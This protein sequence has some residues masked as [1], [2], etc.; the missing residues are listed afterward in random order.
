[1]VLAH[2][3]R[4]LPKRFL[5]PTVATS[6]PDA[7]MNRERNVVPSLR[8]RAPLEAF[9]A[10]NARRVERAVPTAVDA[11]ASLE[12]VPADLAPPPLAVLAA[13]DALQLGE[14]PVVSYFAWTG[15]CAGAEKE[16]AVRGLGCEGEG[17]EGELEEGAGG[18]GREVVARGKGEGRDEGWEEGGGREE[19]QGGRREGRSWRERRGCPPS[20]LDWS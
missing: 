13:A 16:S 6:R 9:R 19:G 12:D 4:T 10:Q 7:R 20:A 15:E 1:M 14:R 18:G 3:H 17:V 8:V 11:L 5:I 2:P